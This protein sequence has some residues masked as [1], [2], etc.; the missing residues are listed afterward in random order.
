MELYGLVIDAWLIIF[1]VISLLIGLG[2]NWTSK[3][4]LRM[5]NTELMQALDK[6]KAETSKLR[7]CLNLTT[8]N[9]GGAREHIKNLEYALRLAEAFRLRFRERHLNLSAIIEPTDDSM[10]IELPNGKE[11]LPVKILCLKGSVMI[12]SND[13]RFECEIPLIR[14]EDPLQMAD[15]II[16]LLN[17]EALYAGDFTPD[18]PEEEEPNS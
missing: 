2:I 3:Q 17:T 13:E 1:S 12:V 7:S 6:E 8:S 10:I 14:A 16:G 5:A 18:E 9:L 4:K 11:F 15:I